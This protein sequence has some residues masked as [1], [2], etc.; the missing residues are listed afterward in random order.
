MQGGGGGG[1]GRKKGVL[2]FPGAPGN[3]LKRA[4]CA[5]PDLGDEGTAYVCLVL[6]GLSLYTDLYRLNVFFFFRIKITYEIT[7]N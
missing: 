3:K 2:S 6:A 4:R 7:S 1:G 5:E